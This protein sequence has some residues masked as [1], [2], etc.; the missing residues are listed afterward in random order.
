MKL[1]GV[2]GW[3]GEGGREGGWRRRAIGQLSEALIL[4]GTR[5]RSRHNTEAS[6][7]GAPLLLAAAPAGEG[8]GGVGGGRGAAAERGNGFICVSETPWHLGQRWG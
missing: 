5:W 6:P 8:G 2:G 7:G 3:M 4:C 1:G